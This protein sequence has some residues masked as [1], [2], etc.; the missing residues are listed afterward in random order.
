MK[1]IL[2]VWNDSD[3]R[4]PSCWYIVN[5]LGEKV[6]IRK[7]SRK[8]AQAVVDKEYGKGKYIVKAD[9]IQHKTKEITAR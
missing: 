4:P 6:Y 3:N 9:H 1:E 7:R 5:C 8:D 2:V